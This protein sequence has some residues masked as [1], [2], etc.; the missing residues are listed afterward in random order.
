M[1]IS[2]PTVQTTHVWETDVP[3]PSDTQSEAEDKLNDVLAGDVTVAADGVIW[4]APTVVLPEAA[5]DSIHDL[6]DVDEDD[7]TYT[8]SN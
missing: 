5:V 3:I 8:Y 4:T 2:D 6:V 7:T 1:S